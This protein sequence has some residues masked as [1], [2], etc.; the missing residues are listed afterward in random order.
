MDGIEFARWVA[1]SDRCGYCTCAASPCRDCTPAFAAEMR[2][3]GRCH[4]M[5]GSDVFP[6]E[7]LALR[8][9]QGGRP[10]RPERRQDSLGREH[11]R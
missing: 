6:V 8:R 7:L 5:P 2:R 3:E 10:A 9:P 1:A 11:L 4:G